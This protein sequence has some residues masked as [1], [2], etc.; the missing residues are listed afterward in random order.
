MQFFTIFVA[1]VDFAMA[2][3]NAGLCVYN[4]MYDGSP[5]SIAISMAA[6][7]FCF[8]CGLYVCITGR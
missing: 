4:M 5:M 3:I 7:V 8:S 2:A 6:A 1:V